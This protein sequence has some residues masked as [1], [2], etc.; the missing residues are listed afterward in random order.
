M[1][2]AYRAAVA[3]LAAA[4]LEIC[5][6]RTAAVGGPSFSFCS[7]SEDLFLLSRVQVRRSFFVF[8]V[9][10][11]ARFFGDD[12]ASRPPLSN[13]SPHPA[14]SCFLVSVREQSV[15]DVVFRLRSCLGRNVFGPSAA[16]RLRVVHFFV[17]SS[18][19]VTA[20]GTGGLRID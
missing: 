2:A 15:K 16:L 14:A 8:F 7:R 12:Q 17:L 10:G 18:P 13:R 3:A 4:A 5:H 1:Q 6:F 19:I 11:R 20:N 9:R